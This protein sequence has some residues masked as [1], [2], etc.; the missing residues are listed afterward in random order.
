MT[1]HSFPPSRIVRTQEKHTVGLSPLAFVFFPMRLWMQ[2]V[3]QW[4]DL[5]TDAE[6]PSSIT[7]HFGRMDRD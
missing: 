7:F 5:M 2:C 4:M 1:V 3:T 6:P